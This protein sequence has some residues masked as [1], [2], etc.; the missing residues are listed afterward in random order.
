MPQGRTAAARGEAASSPSARPMLAQ[1]LAFSLPAPTADAK[2]G[3]AIELPDGRKLAHDGYFFAGNTG[4]AIQGTHINVFCG[5]QAGNCFPG[6]VK[7]QAS[8][9]FAAQVVA[10]DAIAEALRSAPSR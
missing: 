2:G 5:V 7:S 10:D 1:A 4:G 9:G 6:F 3:A 8:A